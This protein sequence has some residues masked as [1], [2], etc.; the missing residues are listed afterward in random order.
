M[1]NYFSSKEELLHKIII[2]KMKGFFDLLK[3]KDINNVQKHEVVGFIDSNLELLKQDLDFFKLYFSLTLQPSVFSLL[4]KEI[5]EIFGVLIEAIHNYYLRKGCKNPYVKTRF[6]L[7]V[8]D[9]IGIHYIIDPNNFPLDE[10]RK[11][12]IDLL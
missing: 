11:M 7:A 12:I 5:M 2:D 4:E 1:Y 10:T 3:I 8:F 6:L 9:G